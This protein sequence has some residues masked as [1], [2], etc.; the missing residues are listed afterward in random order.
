MRQAAVVSSGIFAASIL[1][2]GATAVV[3]VVDYRATTESQDSLASLVEGRAALAFESH[4]NQR[5]PARTFG[6]NLWAAIDYVLFDEG[7][8]GLVLGRGGWLFTDEEFRTYADAEARVQTHLELVTR[9]RDELRRRGSELAVALVPSKAR[10]Y[11]EYLGWRRPAAIH[12][13]LYHRIQRE[14]AATG[15]VRADLLAVLRSGKSQDAVFL[16]T[17]TH[18]TPWGARI[19]AQEVARCLETAK[20]AGLGSAT[21]RTRT[22]PRQSHRGDLFNFLPLDPYFAAL[23]PPSEEIAEPHTEAAA[24]TASAEDLFGDSRI[25]SVA[26][27]GTSYSANA[28]WNFTGAL[29]EALREDVVNYAQEGKGPFVAMLDYLARTDLPATPPRVVIWE[30]PERFFPVAY[31]FSAYPVLLTSPAAVSRAAQ[32]MDH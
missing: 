13:N 9:V 20:L 6:T 30:V 23:L 17:D 22:G 18:W 25:P 19:A 1:V 12:G 11:P 31:D 14:L 7:R 27:I 28:L 8:P 10:V 16:R 29:Q 3:K 2:L 5:F 32:A 26:L 21:Y 15:V 4:Y 24:E